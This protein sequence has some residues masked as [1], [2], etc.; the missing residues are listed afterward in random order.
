MVTQMAR[1]AAETIHKKSRA[2]LK[3]EHVH[4]THSQP[5]ELCQHARRDYWLKSSFPEHRLL[6]LIN[7][8]LP[9]SIDIDFPRI[10]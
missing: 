4:A 1:W 8:N 3:A 7:K 10:Y 6:I 9:F 2:V 5:F